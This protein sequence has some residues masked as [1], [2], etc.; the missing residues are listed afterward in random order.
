MTR[1][2]S[3]ARRPP[4]RVAVRVAV[5]IAVAGIAAWCWWLVR[6]GP[7]VAH[8]DYAVMQ[9][10]L[11]RMLAGH[12]PLVGTYSRTG[13]R[14]PGPIREWLFVGPY[15]LSGRRAAALP[16]TAMLYN[17]FW[18]AA[19][20]WMLA[21]ARALTAL[22]RVGVAVTGACL[23][24]AIGP[25]LSSAWNPH[26]A[27]MPLLGACTALA[28]V[29]A[30]RFDRHRDDGRLAP[31]IIA[32]T[33]ASFAA[34]MHAS[35]LPV[36]VLVIAT[37]FVAELG[38]RRFTPLIAVTV[39]WWWGPLIDLVHGRS[40]NLARILQ[41]G[42]GER[43]GFSVALADWSRLSVPS[44]W[45][46]GL[47]FRPSL[48]TLDGYSRALAFAFALALTV[49]VIVLA[50]RIATGRAPGSLRGEAEAGFVGEVVGAAIVA[51]G[52][53]IAMAAFIMPNYTYLYGPNQAVVLFV[54]GVIAATVGN[55][56]W[57]RW[58]IPVVVGPALLAV[59]ALVMLIRVPVDDHQSA[60]RRELAIP[61]SVAGWL[62]E[63]RD[64]QTVEVVSID[65]RGASAD[66]DV[67]LAAI[68]GGVDVRST[69]TALALPPPTSNVPIIAVAMGDGLACIQQVAADDPT[70]A[71]PLFQGEIAGFGPIG[72]FAIPDRILL[73]APCLSPA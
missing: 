21:R 28:V 62:H 8:N 6:F 42:E 66:A 15:W 14:H 10:A 58:R 38:R 23:V 52:A 22:T 31:A 46:T 16:A 67:A 51:S 50:R 9:I 40:S 37:T 63:H 55:A 72:G 25:N 33:G 19:T 68:R 53:L 20:A 59:V 26:L 36:G 54:I 73:G 5:A 48:Q 61:G 30:N 29:L 43:L 11:E 34:Q 69:N 2:P 64:W 1:D 3:V 12:I 17:L 7:W 32:V 44:S 4:P 65:Q 57:T 41:T 71:V 27:A 39:L 70:V 24:V 13:V 56:W 18:V 45:W 47:A 49:A 35:A 60:A